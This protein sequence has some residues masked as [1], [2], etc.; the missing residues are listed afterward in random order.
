MVE[1]SG[2]EFDDILTEV[3]EEANNEGIETPE[4]PLHRDR[5]RLR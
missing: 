1:E 2:V 4:F 3:L 5:Q